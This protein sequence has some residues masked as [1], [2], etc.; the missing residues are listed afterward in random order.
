MKVHASVRA[1]F[2]DQ[3][4]VAEALK[5]HVDEALLSDKPPRWHFESRLKELSSFAAKLDTGR[6]KRP[7]ALEDFLAC[8]IVVPNSAALANA[9]AWVRK[10]FNVKY[11]RPPDPSA[12]QKFANSFPFDDLRLYCVRG[13]DGSR[14]EEP[15]DEVVFEVQIKTFLQHAWGVAT[16]DLSYKTDDVRWGKDR[17]VSHLKAAVEFAE[18]SLQE[19]E[20]LSHSGA[21]QLSHPQTAETARVIEVLQSFWDRDELPANLRGLAETIRSVVVDSKI[22]L[23]KL[24]EALARQKAKHGSMPANLS[25]YGTVIQT[26]LRDHMTEMAAMLRNPRSRVNLF[27]TSEMELPSGFDVGA[28]AERIVVA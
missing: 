2:D 22:G 12:T 3:R 26:L 5:L 28:Y 4:P 8:S 21:L 24:E 27:V 9:D 1:I 25:P 6:V 7:R 15:I 20:T 14:P 13:N 16:H 10:K 17:I 18:L 23:L 11:Q 19:A